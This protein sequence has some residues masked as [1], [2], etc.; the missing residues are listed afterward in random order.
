M[1][2]CSATNRRTDKKPFDNILNAFA[3]VTDSLAIMEG[4][5][6]A[7]RAISEMSKAF[8]TIHNSETSAVVKEAERL[9]SSTRAASDLANIGNYL[10]PCRVTGTDHRVNSA[11]VRWH[12]SHRSKL[13][14]L[15]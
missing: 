13:E 9:M 5:T 10:P 2:N 14:A 7:T 1:L 11:E 8:N 3:K 15:S 6:G 12:G 4:G